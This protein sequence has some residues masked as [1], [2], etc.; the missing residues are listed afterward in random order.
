MDL[1]ENTI[2]LCLLFQGVFQ[3]LVTFNTLVPLENIQETLHGLGDI[4]KLVEF[5][6]NSK[7]HLSQFFGFENQD[8]DNV[9]EQDFVV[10]F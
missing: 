5:V 7:F 6:N 10:T 1:P 4:N 9:M 2:E 8:S 3:D